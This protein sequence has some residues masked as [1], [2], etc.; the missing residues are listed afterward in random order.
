MMG[1]MSELE[2]MVK[3]MRE[4]GEKIIHLAEEMAEAFSVSEKKET[5]E[6]AKKQLSLAEVRSV[7]AEKSRAGF[8]KEVKELLIKYGADKL[9]EIEPSKYEALLTDAEVL[10]NG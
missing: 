7:L 6:V 2:M 1:K 3:E 10:G 8:T 9:S 5:K 4:Y